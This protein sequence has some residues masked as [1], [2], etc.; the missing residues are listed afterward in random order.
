VKNKTAGPLL[1]HFSI[2]TDPRLDNHNREHKLIDIIIVTICAVICGADDWVSIERWA[3]TKETWLRQFLELPSGIPSHDTFGRVF[4][5]LNPQE[6]QQ[7]FL[8]WVQTA[9]KITD[10]QIV[11]I[12]GK[13]VRRSY[14]QKLGK[15]AIHMVSAFATANGLALGQ[16]K[17]D[18]KSNEIT[19]IPKL[20]KMLEIAGCIITIDAMGCQTEIAE[21]IIKQGADY[22]LAVKGNQ[23]NLYRDL[24]TIFANLSK[25]EHDHYETHESGHGRLEQRDCWAIC[26]TKSLKKIRNADQWAQLTSIAKV[27]SQ[28]TIGNKTTN[29]TRYYVSTL[30][31]DAKQILN[32]TRSH[33]QI[34]NGLHWILDVAFREDDSRIR[35]DHAPENLATIRHIA[36]NLL[37]QEK[38]AKVGIKNK[39]L[40][41]GWNENYLQKVLGV[42]RKN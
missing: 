30:P 37:K 14:N 20:L 1:K 41:A 9:S 24:K 17:V 28:R 29:D 38:T 6:F 34:E 11:A 8:S 31:G 4:S 40:M 10:G 21:T 32:A 19:A 2:I 35:K 16:V 36:L 22:V 26:G 3:K 39:R 27:T 12:D 25:T 42:S 5:L 13:T 7:S 18:N 33:W 15:N 23:G